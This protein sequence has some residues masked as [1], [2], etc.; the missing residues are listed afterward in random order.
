MTTW[1]QRLEGY[2]ASDTG[3]FSDEFLN[4]RAETPWSPT[5]A[6]KEAAAAL[7]TQLSTRVTT[8]PL[9]YGDGVEISA[10]ESLYQLFGR[11]REIQ[12]KHVG[13]VHFETVAWYVLNV[14]VRPFTARWHRRNLAGALSALDDTDEFRDELETLRPFLMLL[15]ELLLEIRDGQRPPK[16]DAEIDRV[17]YELDAEMRQALE[18]GIAPIGSDIQRVCTTAMN[19]AEQAAIKARRKTYDIEGDRVYATGLALS[20]GGIRSAT[21]SLGVLIA[22]A[23]RNL[24]PDFD[25]LSTVSGGGYLGSFLTTFLSSSSDAP[26]IGLEPS[27]RPFKKEEGEAQALR[28]LRHHSK[29]LHSSWVERIVMSASQMYGMFINGIAL[30]SIPVLVALL[31]FWVRKTSASAFDDF[32]LFNVAAGI[33]IFFAVALPVLVRVSAGVKSRADQLLGYIAV[34]MVVLFALW[35]LGFLHQKVDFFNT[36][37]RGLSAYTVAL[38]AAGIVSIICAIAI[39]VIGRRKPRARAPLAAIAGVIAPALVLAL[40]LITYQWLTGSGPSLPS[41]PW[42]PNERIWTISLLLVLTYVFVCVP[43][44]IN[45]TS[46][47]RHYRRKLADAFLIQPAVMK[48]RDRPFDTGVRIKLSEMNQ[49]ARAPYHLLNAALNVPASKS[50]AM[51]GRLTEFFMFSRDFCGSPLTGYARTTEWE[52]LDRG[53]DLGT[54]MATSGAATSPLMGSQTQTYQTFW[55]ALINLRLGYW[56]KNPFHRSPNRC[57]APGVAYLLREMSGQVHEKSRFLNLT[58]GGHIENS[59]VYELLRRR[60][61]YIVAIDGE[62]DPAMTFHA[63]TTLQRLA[64]IDLGVSVEVDLDDLR[65]RKDG[66]S[67]SHFQMCRIRYP[68]TK[69]QT[70]GV[71]YLIYVKLS[72][73]GNEGE[74]IRRYRLDE[75]SFPHHSTADQFFTEAQFEAYR[76]LGEHVGE[77]LFMKAIVGDLN[78]KEKPS[79]EEWFHRAGKSIL[80]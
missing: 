42:M 48:Q 73:T 44:D 63:L 68:E 75:P 33:V 51:Q 64:S 49:R 47:H 71:G 38:Y 53:L 52:M 30:A 59:G 4:R 29:Y 56:L 67:R 57:G 34:P 77:K 41:W 66:L 23:R 9:R 35:A 28:H 24:L 32:P 10:L 14:R 79:I 19:V 37:S 46:P 45:F 61:K 11:T 58:D 60:C 31:E 21:F 65:L 5:S 16:A 76:S 54:A 15:D 2:R 43:L 78:E 13:S 40:E 7:H 22:L 8:Q 6:D 55:I 3:L 18:W 69:T 17:S 1:K 12:D 74:F 36:S 27:Q 26:D 72:L 20:G 80:A 25:Y 70:E 39:G 50:P 62:H